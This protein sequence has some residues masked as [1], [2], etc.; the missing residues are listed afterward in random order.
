VSARNETAA[1]SE[2]EVSTAHSHDLK[3]CAM[4]QRQNLR[5]AVIKERSFVCRNA[6]KGEVRAF[7]FR[8]GTQ[9]GMQSRGKKESTSANDT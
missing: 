2:E 9:I 7:K 8:A 3:H 1:C 4:G 5:V 6:Y